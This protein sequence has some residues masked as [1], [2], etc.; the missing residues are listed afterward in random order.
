MEFRRLQKN[1]NIGNTPVMIAISNLIIA[2]KESTARRPNK[3]SRLALT[4]VKVSKA[5]DARSIEQSGT[6]CVACP[7]A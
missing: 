5:Y 1:V 2:R 6:R 4:Y 7:R 3:G